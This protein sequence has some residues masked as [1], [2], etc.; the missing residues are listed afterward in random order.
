MERSDIILGELP[1][2]IAT[3]YRNAINAIEVYESAKRLLALA[4]HS[5]QYLALVA[6]A[7]TW[8]SSSGFDDPTRR[9]LHEALPRQS[10]GRWLGLLRTLEQSAPLREP[11]ALE[12]SERRDDLESYVELAQRLNLKSN[13]RRPRINDVLEG[14]VQLRNS[15]EHHGQS[16]DVLQ[17]HRDLLRTTVE[18]VLC[19]IPILRSGHLVVAERVVTLRG[20]QV[21]AVFRVHRGGLSRVETK[22]HPVASNL[23]S[24]TAYLRPVGSETF[25]ELAPFILPVGEHVTLLAGLDAKRRAKYICPYAEVPSTDYEEAD[26]E[27]RTRMPFLYDCDIALQFDAL[28]PLA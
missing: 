16:I 12:L 14:L 17:R 25:I 5:V 13:G 9:A 23:S 3:E 26:G 20:G 19:A 15:V 10:F 1:M 11:L 18:Q 28:L 7:A 24:N 2:P 22:R 8:H 4:E 6:C 27:L 21:E